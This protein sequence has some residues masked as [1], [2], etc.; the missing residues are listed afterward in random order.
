MR[1]ERQR[2]CEKRF[3]QNRAFTLIEIM[4]VMAIIA[5]IM[6]MGVPSMMRAMEKDDL[7]RAVRDV[8]EGCKTARDRAILQ[9]VPWV[10][11]VREN[12]QL[13]VEAAPMEMGRPKSA[14]GLDE[15]GEEGRVASNAA[16]PDAP[17]SG[18]P[19]QL[20]EDV[21]VQLIDVNFISYMEAPEARVRFFPN[22][23][24]DEFAIVMA[25]KG[26][27]RSVTVDIIT[28]QATELVAQ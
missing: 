13:N 12:G 15:A 28:G 3:R 14:Y 5:I 7:A 20:G 10:F 4:I 24:A 2:S 18:F 21:M 11:I 22:G 19:R 9:G 1:I 25:W 17:Y 8:I 23:I 26:K 16:A 6:G 27:Q